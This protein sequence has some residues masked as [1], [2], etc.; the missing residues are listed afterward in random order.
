MVFQGSAPKSSLAL[1]CYM[2]P[3]RWLKKS[4]LLWAMNE[5]SDATLSIKD[6]SVV[7]QYPDF[8]PADLPGLPPEIKSIFEIRLVPGSQ[9]IFRSPYKISPI[10]QVELKKQ[11]DELLAKGFIKLS[12][13]PWGQLP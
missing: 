5:V 8:F 3:S 11:I 9:P 1:L 12:V 4:G 13:S 6:I 10:E 7:C 2:F